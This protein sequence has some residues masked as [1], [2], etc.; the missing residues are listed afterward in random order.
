MNEKA[1][2]KKAVILVSGGL[3][4]TTCLAHAIDQGHE[5]YTLSIDYGQRHHAELQAAN[6]LSAHLG[7]SQHRVVK[8]DLSHLT[9]CSLTNSDL[10]IP[11]HTDSSEIPTTYVPG[12]NT[13]FLS[14]A[15]SWA[16]SLQASTVIIGV[17]SVDYSGYPDCRPEYIDAFREL[18]TLGT[19]CGTQGNP[20]EIKTPL[21]HLDK[22][23]TILLGSSV[24]TPYALTISCY[25]A[26]PSGEACGTCDSCVLRKN[27][28]AAAQIPDPTRYIEK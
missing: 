14:I 12:R 18:A 21:L 9:E 8:L 16:E 27:G 28:F 17:S 6:T 7:A 13:I 1:T 2:K 3:D 25:Q 5:C 23:D 10:S 15:L 22:K 19:K 4:S 24:Q 26:T 20:I 11:E